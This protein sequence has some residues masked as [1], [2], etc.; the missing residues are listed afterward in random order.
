ML[1]ISW[2]NGR[3][4]ASLRA[5]IGSS[6]IDRRQLPP[7]L[8][9]L[10]HI[11]SNDDRGHRAT[12]FPQNVPSVANNNERRMEKFSQFAETLANRRK[13]CTESVTVRGL[14]L[15]STLNTLSL[16]STGCSSSC[17]GKQESCTAGIQGERRG[18]P[19]CSDV[20]MCTTGTGAGRDG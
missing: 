20:K 8:A 9:A 7:Y 6:R 16:L 12:N 19:N 18:V 2:L 10:H 4:A 5:K 14:T 11:T 1:C 13:T 17:A 15:P 3:M